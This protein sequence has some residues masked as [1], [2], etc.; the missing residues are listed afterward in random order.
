MKNLIGG[1]KYF[2]GDKNYIYGFKYFFFMMKGSVFFC[3]IYEGVYFT[4]DTF[5]LGVSV[6][7]GGL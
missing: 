1:F 7:I 4:N 5:A 6:I 3:V 2:L